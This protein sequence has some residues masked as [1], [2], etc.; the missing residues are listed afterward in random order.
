MVYIYEK[1]AGGKSGAGDAQT[2][3]GRKKDLEHA[4]LK[5]GKKELGQTTG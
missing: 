3:R 4:I 1:N 2:H 5:K